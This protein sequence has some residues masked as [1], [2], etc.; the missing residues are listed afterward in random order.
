MGMQKR[1]TNRVRFEMGYRARIMAIDGTWH[2]DCFIE[3]ISKTGAKVVVSG[4]VEGLNLT[5]FFLVLSQTG[6][7]YRRCEMK[8]LTGDTIGLWFL[9]PADTAKSDRDDRKAGRRRISAEG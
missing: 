3:D 4:T 2:R 5:E 8:W 6:S 7:S 1:K 9:L